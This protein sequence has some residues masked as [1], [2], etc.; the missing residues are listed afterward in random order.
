MHTVTFL[1]PTLPL[2]G[3]T[4]H[5][6]CM[7][8]LGLPGIYDLVTVVWCLFLSLLKAVDTAQTVTCPE[9]KNPR[10]SGL[11]HRVLVLLLGWLDGPHVPE[12]QAAWLPKELA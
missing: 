7:V 4:I 10:E 1:L 11:S 3:P 9:R 2:T 8:L 6:L 12:M 5:F